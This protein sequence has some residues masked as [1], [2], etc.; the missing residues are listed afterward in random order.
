MRQG[1]QGGQQSDVKNP[2][3]VQVMPRPQ[4][5][6]FWRWWIDFEYR[7]LDRDSRSSIVDG[8][9]ISERRQIQGPNLCTFKI[10]EG[11]MMGG[12]A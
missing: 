7:E 9:D 10:S 11:V 2:I 12:T 3:V 5:I 4:D 8:A 6:L 1:H